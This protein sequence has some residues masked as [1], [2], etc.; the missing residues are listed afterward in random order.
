MSGLMN[1]KDKRTEKLNT[2]NNEISTAKKTWLIAKTDAF[3]KD[4][5]LLA[6]GFEPFGVYNG[7]IYMKL[8]VE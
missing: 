5:D 7:V 4:D 2:L 6:L 1:L 3:I 8:Y